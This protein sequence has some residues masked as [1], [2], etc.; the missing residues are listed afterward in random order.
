MRRYSDINVTPLIDVLLVL[1]IIFLAA[2]PLT[3]RGLDA[4]L[5][6]PAPPPAKGTPPPPTIVL[7]Y[8]ADGRMAI[9][10]QPVTLPELHGRLEAL[11]RDRTDKTLFVMGDSRLAYRHIIEAIDIAKG[12]GVDRVGI[13]TESMRKQ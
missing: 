11:Y 7:E 10:K 1:L 2:L 6:Q 12:A 13:V 5:P 4:A 8:E 3:Q 9:N